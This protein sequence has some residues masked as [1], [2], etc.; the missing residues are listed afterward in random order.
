MSE[1]VRTYRKVNAEVNVAHTWQVDF[2][3][4]MRLESVSLFKW[5]SCCGERL[6]DITVSVLDENPNDRSGCSLWR[7]EFPRRADD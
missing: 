7:M 3:E 4:V 5:T 6:R 1:G 2:G